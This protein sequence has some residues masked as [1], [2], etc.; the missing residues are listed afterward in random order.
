MSDETPRPGD[1][2]VRTGAIVFLVG[3][4]ATLAT[5]APLF[6]GAH[7][8]P[9]AAYFICMLMAVGFVI[10]AAGVLRSVSEQRRRARQA[11]SR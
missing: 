9:S 3:A 10:A 4:V 5:V 11:A 2:L 8:L 1:L 6:L 7:P